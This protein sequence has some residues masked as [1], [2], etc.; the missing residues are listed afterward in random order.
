M[1]ESLPVLVSSSFINTLFLMQFIFKTNCLW[2]TIS[3]S[4]IY[5][6]QIDFVNLHNMCN[7]YAL[8][9]IYNYRINFLLVVDVTIKNIFEGFCNK[10]WNDYVKIKFE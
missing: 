9:S 4:F 7:E 6:K 10:H 8:S 2:I 1:Y 3:N 5:V